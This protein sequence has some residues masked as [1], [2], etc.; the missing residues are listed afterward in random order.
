MSTVFVCLACGKERAA[1]P[2]SA[3]RQSY[4]GAKA[5]Q[6]A[7]KTAWQQRSLAGDPDY[8]ANQRKS[9]QAW[10]REHRRYWA[11]YRRLRPDV[12]DRN[13]RLQM[14]RDRERRQPKTSVLAKMD[15]SAAAKT[16]EP[17]VKGEYWLIPMLAKMDA[18][19]VKIVLVSD[20]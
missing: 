12:A 17:P 18:F 4:C 8:R 14:K 3:G 13:R 6:R 15:A 2:R 5:C 1:S 20:P 7:R 11:E 9:Q 19:R 16:P 10:C